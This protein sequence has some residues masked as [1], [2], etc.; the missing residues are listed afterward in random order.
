MAEN[1]VYLD[2]AGVETDVKHI[3]EQVQALSDAATKINSIIMSDLESH[4]KGESHTNTINKYQ[5]EY[6][7]MLTKNVPDSVKALHEFITTCKNAIVETD[8]QLKG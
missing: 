1:V 3:E 5:T 2:K 6:Q 4:W 8:S 7:T